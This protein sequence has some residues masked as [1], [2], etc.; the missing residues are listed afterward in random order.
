M[1]T[2]YR[3]I[4]TES[5]NACAMGQRVYLPCWIRWERMMAGKH[6]EW[7]SANDPTG[8]SVREFR[9]ARDGSERPVTGALWSSAGRAD[10]SS[11]LVLFG[12]GASGDRYQ[13]PICHLARRLARSG[14]AA[15]AIDGPVHGLRQVGPGGRAA[16]GDEMR[17]ETFVDDMVEDWLWALAAAREHVRVADVAYFGLS[18]G[19]I[20]GIP[21]LAKVPDAKAAVLGLLGT[22]GAGRPF[23]ERV[24]A[25]AAAIR[26]PVLFLMQLEDELFPRDGCLELFDALAGEDKRMHANPGLHPEVPGEEI[27]FSFEFLSTH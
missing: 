7:W 11:P 6:A 1:A 21:T 24:L 14:C 22:T 4:G 25:D 17:R 5:N 26:C 16:L 27:D 12:H 15:L 19:S 20:F 9:L 18:M 13:S 2:K 23:A 10:S 3:S 8:R